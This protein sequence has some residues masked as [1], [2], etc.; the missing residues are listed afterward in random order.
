MT[1]R[2]MVAVELP[3]PVLDG[4]V[5]L[6]RA[7]R[8]R[9]SVREYAGTGVTRAEVAQLL[10]AAQG[11]SGSKGM[12]TAPSAGALYPLEVYL[13]AGDVEALLGGVHRYDPEGH[14][15][16]LLAEGD[17]RPRLSAAALGQDCVRTGA[18]V[19][20]LVSVTSRTTP[21]YGPR[22][23]RYV[24]MEAGHVAQNICLEATALG[25][26][27]VTVGAFDDEAV[28]RALGL[29]SGEQP[30]YLLPV[31]RPA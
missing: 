27:T 11:L 9:R 30:L 1:A 22:G 23:K 17:A 26:G 7:L 19:I 2:T 24:Y 13:V 15:L 18:A 29:R 20:V 5:S 6:E 8:Q 4:A 10:W 12:R 3:R 21:K 14:A 28:A 16:E 31:G 25:L